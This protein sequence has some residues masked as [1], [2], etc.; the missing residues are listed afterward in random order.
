[1]AFHKIE[2]NMNTWKITLCYNYQSKNLMDMNKNQGTGNG[3]KRIRERSFLPGFR[4][5]GETPAGEPKSKSG[6]AVARLRKRAKHMRT[7]Q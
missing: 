4:I 5:K 1:M 2:I 7:W 6:A 3:R